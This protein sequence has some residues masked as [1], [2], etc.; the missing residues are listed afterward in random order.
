M[1]Q[2]GGRDEFIVVGDPGCMV[3]SQ[4]D[5]YRL[6]DVKHSLGASVGMAAGVALSQARRETG[7]RVVALIGDSGF[8]HSGVN[9]LAD[10]AHAGSRMLVVLLDNG[11]TAL[12]G[13]QPHPAS[14]ED[15]RG[16]PRSGVDLA[17]LARQAGAGAV[18]LVDLD[19]GENPRN[20]I[21]AGLGFDGVAVVIA[22]GLCPRHQGG[23]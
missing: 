5:P 22:R 19:R 20:A 17:S 18:T 8:L 23:S 10:A 15:A 2:M 6:M 13:G 16:R 9:G 3:R 4:M 1:D 11:T 21:E 14:P 12:S 7:K